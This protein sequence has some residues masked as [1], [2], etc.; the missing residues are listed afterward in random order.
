M[1]VSTIRQMLEFIVTVLNLIVITSYIF[2]VYYEDKLSKHEYYVKSIDDI[3]KF[4][5][6]YSLEASLF[7]SIYFCM[8]AGIKDNVA[9]TI[10][11]FS[12]IL[13]SIGAI[14]IIINIAKRTKRK[15]QPFVPVMIMMNITAVIFLYRGLKYKIVDFTSIMV[16]LLIFTTVFILFLNKIHRDNEKKYKMIIVYIL[17]VTV[18]MII[19]S[20]MH[21]LIGTEI[22]LSADLI[23]VCV[24]LVIFFIYYA[25]MCK[26][27]ISC[28]VHKIKSQNKE[29]IEAEQ[30][31]ANLAFIDQDIG[32]K[33]VFKLQD[34][35]KSATGIKTAFI[36]GFKCLNKLINLLGNKKS[37][38]ILKLEADLLKDNLNEKY[39]MYSIYNN[40]FVIL[41]QENLDEV[42]NLVK[43]LIE[44]ISSSSA[45]MIDLEPYAGITVIDGGQ[46]EYDKLLSELELACD[47]AKKSPESYSVYEY[48]MYEQLQK[49]LNMQAKL[50]NAIMHDNWEVYLQPKLFLGTNDIAG[51]EAL[52]RWRGNE[53]KIGPDVFIPLAEE[54]GLIG[55]I[56]QYVIRTTF[57]YIGVLY[58]LGYKKFNIAINLSAYQLM[59]NGFID[60]VMKMKDTYGINAENVTFEVTESV[61]INNIELVNDTMKELK[62]VGF[63]FSLDDFGTGYSS[64][65]YLSKMH[66][67]ELKFDRGFTNS[68]MKE[69]K[70][71]II[72]QQVTSMAEKLGLDI[73]SEGVEDKEQ[74]DMMK[75]MGCTYYQG[76]YY[77]KPV[78][79]DDFLSLLMKEHK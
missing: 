39:E 31:I 18:A 48:K 23:L 12:F 33:N 62:K 35:L 13:I 49:N 36:I 20:C 37:I 54:M 40:K 6:A 46:I 28:N 76:Y 75:S 47:N 26:D 53:S 59:D 8:Q 7:V 57:Q 25:D 19:I 42:I 21:K 60:Y 24:D 72:L 65:S 44:I 3:K 43:S 27:K 22:A 64:L 68:S 69:P 70:D 14:A 17:F 73:V 79:F 63:R 58:G 34:D 50:K 51:A 77:S 61:L 16:L 1:E 52:V 4:S 2:F 71:R 30:R 45:C 74:Y 38:E 29:L 11:F 78:P 9:R 67:D 15:K 55:K 32:I 66:L 56:G 10:A 41:S 5:V